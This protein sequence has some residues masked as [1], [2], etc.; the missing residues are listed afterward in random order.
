[1]KKIKYI[2]L[3]LLLSACSLNNTPTSKI[4]ELL[5]K[6]QSLNK[7]IIINTNDLAI[8]GKEEEIKKIIKTQYKNMTYEIKEE[9]IDGEKA[10][11]TVEI[12]V[13]NYK[14]IIN[15]SKEDITKKLKNTKSK[16]TYT[17]D[18]TLTKNKDKWKVDELTEEQKNKLLGIF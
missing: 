5:G 18:F 2:L 1:M 16:I 7:E 13:L 9:K 14:D 11:V 3:I 17:I 4:E 6:Y 8:T 15:N 10:T 12:E